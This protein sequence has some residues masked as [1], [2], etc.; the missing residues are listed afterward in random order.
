MPL[1]NL[2]MPPNALMLTK[3][4]VSMAS[5]DFIPVNSI[6]QYLM[7]FKSK[8]AEELRYIEVG[9]ETKNFILNCGTMLWAIFFWFFS[10]FVYFIIRIL[11]KFL[12]KLKI[13]HVYI[14]NIIFFSMLIVLL[15]E[16]YLEVLIAA[17]V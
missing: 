4:L 6:N 14:G 5:L 2:S 10:V 11:A 13:V 3:S 7:H 8:P 1:V 17:Y 9:M 16:S 12:K 15:L